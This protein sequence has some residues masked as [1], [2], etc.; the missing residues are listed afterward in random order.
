[1][2]SGIVHEIHLDK[3]AL[4]RGIEVRKREHVANSQG[5]EGQHHLTSARTHACT[6][7]SDVRWISGVVCSIISPSKNGSLK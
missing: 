2:G 4:V 6:A 3:K 7:V 5:L 1:M